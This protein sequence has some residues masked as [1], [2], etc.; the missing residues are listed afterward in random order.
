MTKVTDISPYLVGGDK[1]FVAPAGTPL[2]DMLD[3]LVRLGANASV[4]SSAMEHFREA[5]GSPK[6]ELKW[7]LNE[8]LQDRDPGKPNHW[9][10]L[11]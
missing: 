8:R 5:V 7:R 2:K 11:Q 10:G 6:E 3:E 1:L 4:A 9:K